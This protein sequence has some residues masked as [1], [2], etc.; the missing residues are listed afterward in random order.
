[1]LLFIGWIGAANAAPIYTVDAGTLS[2]T[3]QYLG[4]GLSDNFTFSGPQPVSIQG[5]GATAVAVSTLQSL[6]TPFNL[7]LSLIIDDNGNESG[8]AS[9][10]GNNYSAE[11]LDIVATHLMNSSPIVLTAGHLTVSVPA[12]V[13]GE[14]QICAPDIA[15]P[16]SPAPSGT[17]TNPFDVAFGPLSGTLT[18]TYAQFN[19]GSQ[20]TLT[21][22]VFTA[23]ASVPEPAT[24][25][26]A[27]GGLGLLGVRSIRKTTV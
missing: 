14:F 1:M 22:A 27:C 18:V 25:L 16:G 21:S 19:F 12:T 24:W 13:S 26:I 9:A 10:N 6:N 2:Y 11:Y 8:P 17:S 3:N 5:S 23:P 4:S 20:Y 15:C 7:N